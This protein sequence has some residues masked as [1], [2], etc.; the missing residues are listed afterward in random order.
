MQGLVEAGRGRL[1]QDFAK[2]HIMQQYIDLYASL[3]GQ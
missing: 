3:S 2:P 1:E